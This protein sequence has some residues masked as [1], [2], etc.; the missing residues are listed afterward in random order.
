MIFIAG[1]ND[2]EKKLDYKQE[3]VCKECNRQGNLELYMH[4]RYLSLFFIPVFRWGKKYYAKATCCNVIY[5]IDE[6]VIKKLKKG[7]IS[8]IPYDVLKMG[9]I[10]ERAC[11]NCGFISP[12]DFEYCPKC[13]SR[14]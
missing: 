5:N 10:Y 6:E 13:G 9:F 7:E 12:P 8:S 14:L 3:I 1:V 11:I 2:G 4:S